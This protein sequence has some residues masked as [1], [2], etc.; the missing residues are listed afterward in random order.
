MYN[1][2]R[3]VFILPKAWLV[4]ANPTKKD[5]YM[6]FCKNNT[7]RFSCEHGPINKIFSAHTC[8]NWEEHICVEL[9]HHAVIRI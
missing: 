9:E 5:V 3:L 1:V 7:R 6:C 4:I 8:E 2:R